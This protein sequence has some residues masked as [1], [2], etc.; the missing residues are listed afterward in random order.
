[1]EDKFSRELMKLNEE[2]LSLYHSTEYNL[3]KNILKFKSSFKNKEYLRILKKILYMPIDVYKKSK[4][5]DKLPG[6][7]IISIH[8]INKVK[9]AIYTCIIGNYDLV[10]EPRYISS[11]C[12]YFIITDQEVPKSSIWKKID[13]NKFENLKDFSAS[14]K[15]RYIKFFPYKIFKNYDYSIYIDGSIEIIADLTPLIAYLGTS[16]IGL[17][18]HEHRN[19]AY[20]EAKA[21]KYH[22]RYNPKEIDKQI[23]KYSKEGFPKHYGLYD[24]TVI[25][26]KHNE[27]CK[28]IMQKWWKELNKYTFR[29][30]LSLPYTL[31]KY[32]IAKKNI[33]LLPNGINTNP[34][35]R[36]HNHK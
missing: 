2:Y 14:Q 6:Q 11:N 8:S 4:I 20:T 17:H 29:D 25:V 16:S 1:M 28:L 12:D 23:L 13:I 30:Q 3:G 36:K 19:C 35:W 21:I 9:I 31:W 34:R 5:V 10:K 18:K 22:K 26:R 33:A 24:N 15:N 27:I 32:N 7:N